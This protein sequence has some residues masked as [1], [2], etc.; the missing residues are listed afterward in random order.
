MISSTFNN[1]LNILMTEFKGGITKEA[2]SNYLTE[3]R[4]NNYSQKKLKSIVD[5]TNASYEFSFKDLSDLNKIK[6]KSLESYDMVIIAVII[7]SPAT[8]AI[9]ML[10]SAI[11]NTKRYKYRVFSTYEAALFWVNSFSL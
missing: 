7:N 8:A 5:A 4:E 11:A 10:F 2:I 9:S 6:N 3:F 1:Q